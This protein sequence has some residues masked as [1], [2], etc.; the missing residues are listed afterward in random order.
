MNIGSLGYVIPQIVQMQILVIASPEG[1]MQHST[2][3]VAISS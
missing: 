1:N 3:G 2:K